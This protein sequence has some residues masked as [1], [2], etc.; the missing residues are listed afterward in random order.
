MAIVRAIADLCKSLQMATTAEGVETEEQYRCVASIGCTA[1]QG[2]LFGAPRPASDVRTYI[3]P[4][5]RKVP[6][7]SQTHG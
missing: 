1:A 2:F 7:I 4:F 6:S 3:A 5:E